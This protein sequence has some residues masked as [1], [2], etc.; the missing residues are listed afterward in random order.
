MIEGT[1]SS[2][3]KSPPR[4]LGWPGSLI[5]PGIYSPSPLEFPLEQAEPAEPCFHPRDSSTFIETLKIKELSRPEGVSLVA[6][7][8]KNMPVM[9]ETHV[10]FL[11]QEGPLEE[12]TVTHSSILAWRKNPPPKKKESQRQRS[13]VGY[14]PWGRKELDATEHAPRP[15]VNVSGAQKLFL[16]NSR[17][18]YAEG[19]LCHLHT[20]PRGQCS[21][22]CPALGCLGFP[23]NLP[24]L[25]P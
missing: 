24:L 17:L 1:Q 6:Q 19:G 25:V 13:P 10:R 22:T 8:V 20:I 3:A 7:V 18:C 5:P 9:Q 2:L 14:S 23:F 4:A 15:T 21:R 11:Y 16:G 12:G